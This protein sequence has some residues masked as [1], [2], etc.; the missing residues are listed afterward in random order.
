MQ[1]HYIVVEPSQIVAQDLAHAI[2]AFDPK[3]KVQL[4]S[5]AADALAVLA[6]A[7]PAAVFLHR[8]P[9][10]DRSIQVG[11]ALWDAGVPIAFT[12]VEAEM[13][14]A[15]AEVLDS[16]FTEAT[17]AALLQRLLAQERTDEA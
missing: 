2:R 11:R 13:S 17:V 3:A 16:P 14:V 8:E 7:K 15:G 4:L 10:S 6:E 9:A 1:N 5:D 12:G